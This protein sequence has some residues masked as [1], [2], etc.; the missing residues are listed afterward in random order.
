MAQ[1]EPPKQHN[2]WTPGQK[3]EYFSKLQKQWIEAKVID[4][5]KDDEGDWVKVRYGRNITEVPPDSN[6]I[7]V[8]SQSNLTEQSSEWKTGTLCEVY[9]HDAR[10]WIEG[11]IINTFTDELGDCLRVQYGQRIRD[12]MTDDPLFRPRGT[13]NIAVSEDAL[14]M[15]RKLALKHSDLMPIFEGILSESGDS[16]SN[17]TKS[18]SLSL[19]LWMCS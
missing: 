8:P 1:A 16:G 15:L 6:D 3:C 11:E 9:S 19:S 7:R 13:R 14:K 18:Y 10:Q 5:F 12:V 17:L 2:Q 4:V